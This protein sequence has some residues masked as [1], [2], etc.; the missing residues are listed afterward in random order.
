MGV[1]RRATIGLLLL[2]SGCVR[3][4]EYELRGQV[5]A[6]DRARQELTIKHGDIRGFM[7]GMTMPFKV[8]DAKLLAGRAPGDLVTATLVVGD[9]AAYLSAVSTTGHAALTEA[10]P[11][12]LMDV[13]EDGAAVPDVRLTDASGARR[14]LSDWRGRVL[15]V[16]FIYTRCPL[17]DFCLRMDQNFAAVQRALLEDA[18]LRDRAALLSISFDP[19]HDT[20]AVLAEHARH[21]G[22]DARVW[23]FATGD[24]DSVARFAGRFGISVFRE[25]T[26]PEGLTHNLRTAVIKPDGTLLTILNGNDWT[27]ATLLDAVRHAGI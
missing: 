17:P 4:R 8:R 11:A 25:G 13:L 16:T 23:Q 24:E 3:G 14:S 2:L 6:V 5:L 18:A 9:D 21:A 15:A 1:W 20:P 19:Q 7:P 10:P 22:A 27:A 12:R 26:A